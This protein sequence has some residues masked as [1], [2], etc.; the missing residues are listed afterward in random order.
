LVTL[1]AALLASVR[2][3][4]LRRRRLICVAPV[5]ARSQ[6]APW[7][8]FAHRCWHRGYFVRPMT[9]AEV[10]LRAVALLLC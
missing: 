1:P 8:P 10:A 3:P 2:P 5:A 7:R 6:L 4:R 9:F